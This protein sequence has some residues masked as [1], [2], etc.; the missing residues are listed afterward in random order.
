MNQAY[1]FF[2][3]AI[4]LGIGIGNAR[5]KDA[6]LLELGAPFTDNAIFERES[7]AP[8]WGWA[9]PGTRH[10]HGRAC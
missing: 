9:K 7:D 5:S 10:R 8:V 1:S 2:P 6:P 4:L 3:F